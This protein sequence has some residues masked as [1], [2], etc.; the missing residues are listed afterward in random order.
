MI[1]RI[2]LF[3]VLGLLVITGIKKLI[4]GFY[5]R[6]LLNIV[7][8]RF[9]GRRIVLMALNANF[10]GIKTLGVKQVRGNGALILTDDELWFCLAAPRREISIPLNLIDKI[11]LKRSHLGKTAF[12]SLLAVSF[13]YQGKT[14]QIAWYVGDADKWRQAIENI[15][16]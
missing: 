12:R 6:R 10:F 14:E 7:E 8:E 15:K 2:L 9:A 11:E 13:N 5:Q 16:G 1:F 4:L 3:V